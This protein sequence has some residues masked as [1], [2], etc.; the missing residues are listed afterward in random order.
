MTV[1]PTV[2]RNVHYYDFDRYGEL[3]AYAAIVTDVP[4]LLSEGPNSGP[5][6]YTKS[7]SLAIF[8]PLGTIYIINAPYSDEPEARHWSWIRHGSYDQKKG[9]R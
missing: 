2:A 8:Q 4:E 1:Q 7:V 6:G 5:D 9:E 3:K